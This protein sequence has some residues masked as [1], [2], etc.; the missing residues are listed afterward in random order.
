MK[1]AYDLAS[2]IFATLMIAIAA[3][4]LANGWLGGTWWTVLCFA[5]AALAILGPIQRRLVD[6]MIERG[7][8][9]AEHDPP[10]P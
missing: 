7:R 4:N 6:R 5:L 10:R 1:R 2:A 3:T 9:Q 8:A